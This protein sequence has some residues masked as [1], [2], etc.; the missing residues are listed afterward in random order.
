MTW[1]GVRNW[2]LVPALFSFAQQILVQNALHVLVLRGDVQCV[3]GFR[4][5]DEQA[6]FVDL[7]LG[8]FHLR[9]ERAT[10]AAERVDERKYRF[11]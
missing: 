5:L 11:L 6:W 9:R 8:V 4:R 1:R 3:D 10:C 2:A 7:E